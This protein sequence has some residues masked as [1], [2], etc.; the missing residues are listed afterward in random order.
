M[1]TFILGKDAALENSIEH[2]QQTL[3]NLGFHIEEVSWLNP[4][5]HVWSVHIRDKDCPQCFSNGK[6]ASQKAALASALGE[7]CERLATNYY[8]ADYYLGKNW[9]AKHG[10]VHYPQEKWLPLSENIAQNAEFLSPELK[11]HYDP[12]NEIAVD[13]LLDLQSA[14]ENSGVALL[15]FV[16]ET[17]Q[18]TVY[19]PQSIIHNLYVSNGLSAGN[20]FSEAKVQGL[21]EVFERFVKNKI[22]R[23]SISLPEIPAEVIAQYPTIA[24]SIAKLEEAGFPIFPYDA[25]LGGAYP[26][27]CVVLFNPTNGTC[28]ASF[29]AHPNFEVAFERTVTELLQGRSLKDLDVFTP[30][31]FDNDAVAEWTNLETHFIDSSG[32]ISWDLFKK[33]PDYPFVHWNFSAPT[34]QEELR[35]L[36]DLIHA[37]GCEVYSMEY[38][39]IGVPAVRL[40]VPGMSE[41]YPVEDLLYA[42]NDV[43]NKWR[44]TL[45]NLGQASA[46]DLSAM[47][48]D[49]D[50]YGLDDAMRLRE[51]LGI[52]PEKTSAWFDLR[53]GELK[54]LVN[55]ALGD[56]ENAQLW[57]EWTWDMNA[58]NM[59]PQKRSQYR[60]LMACLEL[61]LDES[62]DRSEYQTAFEKMYGKP[63]LDQAWAI[64]DGD[65]DPFGHL[66]QI[67]EDLT[68]L[69]PHQKLL[70][71]YE[72]AHKAKL[73]AL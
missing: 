50:E 64:I 32:L 60:A 1:S 19:I 56:L 35:N 17:D 57:L 61:A 73:N 23:E 11:K 44:E 70:A 68:A 9:H 38:R 31:S 14:N 41:I 54:A 72:K 52:L 33:T 21:S 27:I 43:A 46:E 12:N 48:E 10:F 67:D 69:A 39:H 47:L 71:A 53:L 62:R 22:I 51:F 13:T 58:H 4:V 6:G 29:G 7:F 55:L 37:Q 18:A 36:V 20:T 25:S 66:E 45:F 24:T 65:C 42:Q 26:V 63:A 16:R 40:L 30:P 2:F 5:P 49:F 15:P 59:Q 34:T 3:A 8:F 28:F